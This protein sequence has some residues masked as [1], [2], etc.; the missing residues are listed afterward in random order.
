MIWSM[1]CEERNLARIS[2][3]K[4]GLLLVKSHLGGPYCDIQ[5]CKCFMSI[6]VVLECVLW[7]KGYL[8]NVSAIRRYSLPLMDKV[9]CY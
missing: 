3:K 2:D 8:L 6:S 7:M 1:H 5:S 4:G 9:V